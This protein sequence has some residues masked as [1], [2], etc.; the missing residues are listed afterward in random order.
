MAIAY[1]ANYNLEVDPEKRQKV[2]KTSDLQPPQFGK[3]NTCAANK[4]KQ[5]I[6]LEELIDIT[7]VGSIII[8]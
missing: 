6:P 4:A 1:T 7:F 5:I 3:Q 2:E 8:I